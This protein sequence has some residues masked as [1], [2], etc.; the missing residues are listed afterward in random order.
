MASGRA[1]AEAQ[2]CRGLDPRAGWL[3]RR[4][5]HSI[6]LLVPLVL[7]SLRSA[8]AL[9]AALESR[10][11]GMLPRRTS[12]Q[13]G[14]FGWQEG[15]AVGLPLAAFAAVGALRMTGRML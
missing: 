11:M 14:R 3:L 13:P 2:A 10:G 9:A 7:M 1:I 15:V 8:G 12:V 6:P 5:R 4:L